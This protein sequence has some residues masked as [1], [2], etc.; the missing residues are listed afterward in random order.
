MH[1]FYAL[2]SGPWHPEDEAMLNAAVEACEAGQDWYAFPIAAA[3]SQKATEEQLPIFDRLVRA[4]PQDRYLIRR[5]RNAARERLGVTTPLK[6]S[7]GEAAAPREWM[8]E[9]D[10]EADGA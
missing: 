10:D 4:S 3:L 6:V 2:P 9:P 1:A 7:P 5:C 8:D